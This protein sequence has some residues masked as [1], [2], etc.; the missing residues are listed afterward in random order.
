VAIA[1][2]FSAY[3]AYFEVFT[4]D[5]SVFKITQ[6]V[7]EHPRWS[8]NSPKS[9]SSFIL[10]APWLNDDQLLQIFGRNY[11]DESSLTDLFIDLL[12]GSEKQV[13]DCVGTPEELRVSL[14]ALEARERFF[15]TELMQVAR[16]KKLL[17]DDSAAQLR[18]IAGKL[19]VHAFPEELSSKIEIILKEK[20]A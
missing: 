5:N 6:E 10:L 11:L 15:D 3:P 16:D 4:S 18:A 1:R 20:L 17:V 2:I 7:R 9:L 14:S 19:D 13:L 12:G 8:L